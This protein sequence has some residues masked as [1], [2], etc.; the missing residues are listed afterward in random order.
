[1][2]S[3]TVFLCLLCLLFLTVFTSSSSSSSTRRE[4]FLSFY[5]G[6]G[7]NGLDT[8]DTKIGNGGI[9][10]TG[11]TI[12]L[13]S[14]KVT[15]LF[16]IFDSVYFDPKS[17]NLLCVYGQSL[18]SSSAGASA[19]GYLGCTPSSTF[20]STNTPDTAGISITSVDV[21]PPLGPSNKQNYTSSSTPDPTLV[22]A[23]NTASCLTWEYTMTNTNNCSN[24]Q[25]F[26]FKN[27]LN[28]YIHVFDIISQ[29]HVCTTQCLY[30]TGTYQQV[31]YTNT[32][33]SSKTK[34]NDVKN[35]Y[36]PT[37][38]PY[39][40]NNVINAPYR[41]EG[42]NYYDKARKNLFQITEYVLFDQDNYNLLVLT[43]G[44]VYGYT[45]NFAYADTGTEPQYSFIGTADTSVG[46]NSQPAKYQGKD[47]EFNAFMVCDTKGQNLVLYIHSN[48][49]VI[50]G[51]Y[52][53]D[54]RNTT[55]SKT[56][57][58]RTVMFFDKGQVSQCL[59]GGGGSDN[60]SSSSSSSGKKS[61]WV[62]INGFDW[63]TYIGGD[64]Y[65]VDLSLLNKKKTSSGASG[66]GTTGVC[67]GTYVKDKTLDD[68]I[69]DY[70]TNY[71]NP[72]TGQYSDDY[73]LKS[74]II[75]PMCPVG[76][77]YIRDNHS[78]SGGGGGDSG[79]GGGGDSGGGGGGGGSGGS[80]DEWGFGGSDGGF[81][82]GS[83]NDDDDSDG[84]SDGGGGSDDD[85]DS[86]SDAG[87]D[88]SSINGLWRN[89]YTLSN[90]LRAAKTSGGG[91]LPV[92]ASF[93][94]FGK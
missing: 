85:D 76:T 89:S 59:V 38:Y 36:T 19:T 90:T 23:T 13:Y 52:Y 80:G 39:T 82:Y 35:K 5:G 50:I 79:G 27:G 25:V 77:P 86:S 49:Y 71:W 24:Y 64:V 87:S 54:P 48:Q 11:A 91:Y 41:S 69:S 47:S 12:N 18:L 21:V 75:P 32:Y 81:G 45:Y 17:A 6:Y 46:I 73:L 58:N 70:Y 28:T 88:Q 14:P 51:L 30:S 34:N 67:P 40:Q 65:V 84:G 62:D 63:A 31:Y 60:N 44:T 16:K 10:M 43:D 57:V 3:L 26:Y 66:G 37:P 33:N 20:T 68:V 93:A 61:K 42:L 15:N 1:M 83:D 78:D 9:A 7:D 4:T 53:Q 2:K 22:F 55:N 94:A 8:T 72:C 29:A 74:Q 56:F 92:T